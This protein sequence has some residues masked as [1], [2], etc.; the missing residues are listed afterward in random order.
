MPSHAYKNPES[1]SKNN[2]LQYNFAMQVLEKSK[3]CPED[4]VLDLGCGDGRITSHIA[5][6]THEGC[7]I[8]TDISE[9]MTEHANTTYRSQT[10][11]RFL[12]MDTSKNVFKNQF[13]VITSFNSLHWVK[14]QENALKGINA[15]AT[16]NARIVLLLSHR[17]SSY[18]LTLDTLCASPKWSSYFKEYINPRSFF[19]KE[20]YNNLLLSA[21]S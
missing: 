7:V 1:Y 21:R 14:D 4:R 15:A 16:N 9:K 8:G 13:D 5:R 12:P 18:H 17:K 6:I 10:N 19:T 11:L 2:N 20:H 3:I